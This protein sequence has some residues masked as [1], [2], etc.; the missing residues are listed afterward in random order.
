MAIEIPEVIG[1]QP[2]NPKP[3]SILPS[4]AISG[5][6]APETVDFLSRRTDYALGEDSPGIDILRSEYASGNEARIRQQAA[7]RE[8]INFRKQKQKAIAE[9]AAAAA[10]E[11]RTFSFEEEQ[12]M[13][14]LT[15]EET[16]DPSTIIE[17]KYAKT[18]V[19]SLISATDPDDDNMAAQ[20]A[21]EDPEGTAKVF[22]AAEA[23]VARQQVAV[24]LLQ[25]TMTQYEKSSWTRWGWDMGKMMF[26]M[27][28]WW[29]INSSIEGVAPTEF[30][31]GENLSEQIAALHMLPIDEFKARSEATLKTLTES[32]IFDA[33]AFA[34]ALVEYSGNMAA[35]DNAFTML[36]VATAPFAAKAGF[37]AARRTLGGMRRVGQPA[38]KAGQQFIVPGPGVTPPPTL[39]RAP[40]K[41][42]PRPTKKT[43]PVHPMVKELQRRVAAAVAA[44]A[45]TKMT[46]ADA[47][48]ASGNVAKA[49]EEKTLEDIVKVVN[50]DAARGT[51]PRQASEL[52]NAQPALGDPRIYARN[53]G[54]LANER[55][56]RL[57][58]FIAGVSDNLVRI[59]KDV[60]VLPRV[61]APAAI[62][63]MFKNAETEWLKT[64]SALEDT[65]LDIVPERVSEAN[66]AGVDQIAV[67]LGHK[68]ALPFQGA[69]QAENFAKNLY[70]LPEGGY[71][72]VPW[73]G[74]YAIR[75]TKPVD[76]TESGVTE[77]RTFGT[78]NQQPA[79]LLKSFL[80]IIRTPNDTLGEA[81][82]Q[83]R[84]L[85][86]YGGNEAVRYMRNAAVALGGLTKTGKQRLNALLDAN[87][88]ES[89]V[90]NL[91]DG[92]QAKLPGNWYDTYA[93]YVEAYVKRFNAKPTDAEIESYFTFRQISI[94]D[95]MSRNMAIYRDKA[96]L[97][98]EQKAIS[99]GQKGA[100]GKSTTMT[101]DFFDGRTVQQL[102]NFD[103][104]PWT[105]AI[106]DAKGKKQ[107]WLSTKMFAAQ[108]K[109][110]QEMVDSGR[111][112]I[113]QP[114]NAGDN[115]LREFFQSKGEVVNY[116][117]APMVKTKPLN[118]IQ[119]DYRYGMHNMLSQDGKFI[120]QTNSWRSKFGR[121]MIGPDKTL[122]YFQTGAQAQKFVKAFNTARE[123]IIR[124]V[125]EAELTKFVTRNLPYQSGKAFKA[126]FKLDKTKE[127]F[128]LNTPFVV[129]NA[130]Q[131]TTEATDMRKVFND[132]L[133][134]LSRSEHNPMVGVN[135]TGMNRAEDV[136]HTVDEIGTEANPAYKLAPTP[137][138]NPIE[139]MNRSLHDLLRNRFLEDYKH[140][141]I[142]D[143]HRQY[144]S[145]LDMTPQEIASNP[146]AALKNP[147]WKSGNTAL[148]VSAGNDRRSILYLIGQNTPIK[149]AFVAWRE[150]IL[151]NAYTRWGQ[152][153]VR[154]I[155][156]KLWTDKTNPV[157]MLRGAT[158]A[159]KLGLWNPVQLFLQSQAVLTAAAIDGNP[160]R[161]S[162]AVAL[163]WMHRAMRMGEINPGY[164][165]AL[166][167]I[168]YGALGIDKATYLEMYNGIKKSGMMN[169]GG[170]VAMLDDFLD[171][172]IVT[173][174]MGSFW[175]SN[176]LFFNE[177][178]RIVRMT[179][180]NTAYLA[181]RAKNPGVKLTPKIE[182]ALV[183]RADLMSMSMTRASNNP[184]LQGKVT[185]AVTQF[186]TFH[187]RLTE[188]MLGGRLNWKEKGRMMLLYSAM[189][190]VPLGTGGI[191]LGAF[192]PVYDMYR[193][194]AL[195]NNIDFN[196]PYV[197]MFFEG[198]PSFLLSQVMG[199]DVNFSERY[200]PGG[201]SWLRDLLVDGD[202]FVLMGV[203]GSFAKDVIANHEPFTYALYS[204]FYP[205]VDGPFRITTEDFIRV[206]REVSTVNNVVKGW[207]AWNTGELLTKGGLVVDN[208][209]DKRMA[210][211]MAITGMQPQAATDVWLMNK[212]NDNFRAAKLELER[213]AKTY[214]DRGLRAAQQGDRKE[215][216]QNFLNAAVILQGG[217]YSAIELGRIWQ[218]FLTNDNK[219]LIDQVGPDFI[220]NAPADERQ[221]R[222]DMWK[223]QQFEQLN[224]QEK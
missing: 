89:R 47:L 139:V 78:D 10:A 41:G 211:F 87:R 204:I 185:G 63:R 180:W 20:A 103:A 46:K 28:T 81:H 201:L 58:E 164:T 189:Y 210:A 135:T 22:D 96:R 171:P 169:I 105:V 17:R 75:M 9:V 181:W 200:G 33:V 215:A 173:S 156:P 150:A 1:Q 205:S 79:G 57:T 26:P 104:E 187:T 120:K 166:A 142:E 3:I 131:K 36:D 168:A 73:K 24:D 109:Q 59:W 188:M 162:Q 42:E 213:M 8:Q 68:N 121:R 157:G 136:L 140:M 65:V 86:T 133:Y 160:L 66:F 178:E 76:E 113:I 93:E 83:A 182:R 84:L 32:N 123:M 155:E 194:W 15:Q 219:S 53:A 112:Q 191:T 6:P 193:S 106:V 52:F 102:P 134:D 44:N 72:V 224:K 45:S 118:A 60:S 218:R 107:L 91:P 97:G 12:E 119:V 90:Y 141:A 77:L 137:T 175:A 167:R 129:T 11:G 159:A 85:T 151:D 31:I 43:A 61:T 30:M 195:E 199:E 144:A 7:I 114:F 198:M 29:N 92:T 212:A 110:L 216:Q 34:H 71:D 40:K 176:R 64:Y 19:D 35:W 202:P 27:Y 115:V 101:T 82:R 99:F 130:G 183:D 126:L 152:K 223:Q 108:K 80:N 4:S 196:Q 51:P 220:L 62:T 21:A 221:K 149:D 37:G 132:E 184:A 18:F 177:G 23:I 48:A 56:R 38:G 165:S 207:Y 208:A 49:A 39:K 25:K 186:F 209:V 148:R 122:M 74:N 190:G 192:L 54:T 203:S 174:P 125:S 143:W 116:V 206:F 117:M 111:F 214:F 145:V 13:M 138:L 128:D 153:G 172:E 217:G 55:V 16:E 179:A 14:M 161:A 197:K 124:N 95:W 70:R 98:G 147:R 50:P 100:D 5:A 146:L 127:G 222:L 67:Y 69:E 163:S 2:L 158:F 94:W 170:E 154:A 88:F